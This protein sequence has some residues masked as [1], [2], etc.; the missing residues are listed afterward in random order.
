MIEGNEPVHEN[1]G[2]DLGNDLD[3]DGDPPRVWDETLEK[4]GCAFSRSIGDHVAKS[5]GVISEPEILEWSISP[6]DKFAIVASDGV[7]EFITSQSVVDMVAKFTDPIEAAKQVLA[8]SYRLW[9]TFD[10]RTDDITMIIIYFDDFKQSSSSA[11]TSSSSSSG[12]LQQLSTA[13]VLQRNP[14]FPALL[15]ENKP[16]RK[17]CIHVT[18]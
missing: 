5:V 10:E 15:Q 13:P 9:L 4:P 11:S 8:E 14:S 2:T 1:F 12:P 6:R 17:V 16:V 18:C 3:E 7:F